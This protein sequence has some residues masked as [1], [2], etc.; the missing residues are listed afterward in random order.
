[1]AGRETNKRA[2]AKT[3]EETRRTRTI[4]RAICQASTSRLGNLSVFRRGRRSPREGCEAKV[5]SAVRAKHNSVG[6]LLES[7]RAAATSEIFEAF[8]HRACRS[9]EEADVIEREVLAGFSATL[10]SWWSVHGKLGNCHS[11]I[12]SRLECWA[13]TVREYC[14]RGPVDPGLRHN[15]GHIR[16]MG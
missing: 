14:R 4:T 7:R 16:L 5:F 11:L 9:I 8:R 3:R 13:A 10:E 15:A 6:H 12:Y 1:M 2:S